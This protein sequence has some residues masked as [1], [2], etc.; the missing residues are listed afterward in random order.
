MMHSETR[1]DLY[2]NY[3]ILILFPDNFDKYFPRV[4]LKKKKLQ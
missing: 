3:F 1:V 4:N 2:E